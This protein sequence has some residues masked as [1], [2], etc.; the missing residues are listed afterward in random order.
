MHDFAL[1]DDPSFDAHRARGAHPE[2][3]ERLDAARAGAERALAGAAVLRLETPEARRDELAS[4]HG[5]AYLDALEAVLAEG[6]AQLDE[7]TYC[8]PGSRE[9]ALRAA[10]GAARLARALMG[11][12]ARRGMAL[13]RPPGHHAEADRAMGFCLL[14]N[15]AIA[16]EA[17]LAA[18]ARRVAIVDWDVHHGNGT[19][20][21]FEE[22]ADVL[23]VSLHQW[24]LYPG[25]GRASEVGRGAGAGR[26]LNVALP[27]GAG[28]EA[29]GEAFRRVVRPALHAHAPDLIL[30]SAGFDAHAR[31]PLASMELSSAMYGAM[32]ST[33]VSVAEALGH[34]RVGFL[35]EG[36]YDL[37]ALEESVAATIAAALGTTREL[38]EDRPPARALGAIEATVAAASAAWPEPFRRE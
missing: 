25:T 9:A 3:P 28:D 23:F 5:A 6:W 22:R 11:G 29:Y 18:G 1:L 12:E 4:I 15:V 14:N 35:L 16:A 2:R 31:D 38:P 13:L 27:A 21:S 32:A 10:G 8:S 26:T 36:G 20:H 34:G 30:V 33:I 37:V 7:D 24:P 19:Q 17:A